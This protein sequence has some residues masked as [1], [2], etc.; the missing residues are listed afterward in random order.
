MMNKL[1]LGLL[2]LVAS[3]WANAQVQSD[4]SLLTLHRIYASGEFRADF[5]PTINWVANGNAYVITEMNGKHQSEL[6]K[7]ETAS[8]KKSVLL[9]A[10]DLTPEGATYPIGMS[11]FSMSDDESKILIFTN[12]K[13]VW[14]SNTKG[15]YWVF[16]LTTRK[17]K[18]L[19]AGFPASSLMFAKFS[20][21][22]RS[23]AYVVDFNLYVEDFTSG[24]TT[25]ITTDGNGD[26]INGTFDWVYE[27]EFGC[28]DGFRW[29]P[30]GK[31]I[32]YWQ[33]DA[34]HIGTF[35]MINNTDSI[36]PEVIPVQYPKA[37]QNPSSAKI[38]LVDPINGKTEW[39]ALDGDPV[40]NYIP[41]IQW[42]SEH[43][44]LIQQ[45][46]RK[47][48]DL[49]VWAYDLSTKQKRLVYEEKN[50]SWIDL[51]Y[52]DVSSNHW[53][54]NDLILVDRA[55]SF[56]RM[57]ED[58]WRKIY[59][60]NIETGAK[61]LISPADYDVATVSGV[62]EKDLYYMASPEEMSQRYLYAVDLGGKQKAHRLTPDTYSGVNNY[63]ISPNGKY[64][65]HTFT[66]ALQPTQI[67]LVSLP[68]HKLIKTMVSNERL[69]EKLKTLEL[70][71]V[72]F[73]QVETEDGLT[74]DGRM[75]KPADFVATKKYPVLFHV[76][77]EPWGQ[78]AL[79]SYIGLWNVMMAQKGFIVI[80]IDGRGTPSLRGS[81]W[82]KSIY[83]NLGRINIKDMGQAARE[84]LKFPY[85]DCEKVAVWGWSGGG[86][87]TLNLMFQYPDVFQTGVAVAA[88]ANQLTYDNI[89][90]ERYMGLPQENLEDFVNGSPISHVSGLEGNLLVIHG[91]GDDN[92]HYQNTEMLINELIRQNKQFSL[93][94]YPNRSHGIYE[95][96]NTSRHLY[97]LIT[98]YLL[99]HMK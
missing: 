1:F 44:L 53:A 87:S 72:D 19:G 42:V 86:S 95:G 2:L 47:Q 9:S 33:L 35:Y 3:F 38:G 11:N 32:A 92:V 89:Y 16:D 36:Y 21:D 61:H 29:C 73:F 13:R 8:G 69:T 64:A 37:G 78:V 97:T 25:K 12:T 81:A 56:L 31:T 58:D 41:G 43:L 55:K 59:K 45:I 15:D 76:Y 54:S 24:K 5:Q 60:V 18:Q 40:Q 99:E 4:S 88:V 51:L 14:R 10:A 28:R 23:V 20:E 63:N 75:I 96:Q 39:I 6:V 82:R 46:N 49:K 26:I 52:P 84:I 57:T 68:D 91:T 85:L 98:N 79:D 83:R 62:S 70:P 93:M 66:S 77:G 74:V 90:Q 30:D 65:V 34:S 71:V 22:N 27:E 50:N 7:Y 80:D 48:N 17:L 94:A 67:E